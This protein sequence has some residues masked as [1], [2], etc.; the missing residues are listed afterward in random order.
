MSEILKDNSI[1][2]INVLSSDDWQY[3]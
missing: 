1:L 2:L 3:L